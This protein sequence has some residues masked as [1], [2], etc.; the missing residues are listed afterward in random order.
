M[1]I[2]FSNISFIEVI[3]IQDLGEGSRV[4][5]D[6]TDSFNKDEG[7]FI[8][9]TSEGY[10]FVMSENREAK[11]Y[12]PRPFRINAGAIHQYILLG[13]KTAYLSDL[14]SS[15]KIPVVNNDDFREMIIGRIKIE[16]R[17]FLRITCKCEDKIISATFQNA[18]SVY[19]LEEQKNIIRINELKVGDKIKCYS[20]VPGRHL[21][22][23][24]EEFINE[25]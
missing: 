10:V 24:I 7:V 23:K 1:E 15:M 8:G 21:G 4:C 9:N 17:N 12:L 11:D 13:N 19:L 5:V 3:D 25:K 2:Q 6:F 20:D 18:E 22:D 16:K 14:K